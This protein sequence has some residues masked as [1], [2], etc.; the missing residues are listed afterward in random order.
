MTDDAFIKIINRAE[1]LKTCAD[2]IMQGAQE[3]NSESVALALINASM[4][5]DEITDIFHASYNAA[6][7]PAPL[8]VKG[9]CDEAR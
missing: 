9:L 4:E 6:T 3:R 7:D 5:F 2:C 1:A 8:A